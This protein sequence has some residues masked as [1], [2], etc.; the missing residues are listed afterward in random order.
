[1]EALAGDLV[2]H[3]GLGLSI[4]KQFVALMHGTAHYAVN[5]V[6]AV[7]MAEKHVYDLVLMDLMMPKLDGCHAAEAIRATYAKRNYPSPSI[8]ANSYQ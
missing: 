3:T 7:A 4:A 1:M 6:D 8:V 2:A 5:G